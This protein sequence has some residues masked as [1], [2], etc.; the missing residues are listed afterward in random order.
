MD[1]VLRGLVMY[2]L[3]LLVFRLSGKRTL[4]QIT[5]FDFV[6]LLIISE[7]TQQAL[8]RNDFSMTQSALV[9]LT[10]VAADRFADLIAWRSRRADRAL[11]SGPIVLVDHGEP[12]RDRM[13]MARISEDDI[14]EQARTTQGLRGMG[15][16]DFAVLERSGTISIIPARGEGD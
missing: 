6:L 11:N 10:L 1:A 14:L 7:A 13:A 15:E 4:A 16:I 5:A 8:L 3:L 9:I 12:L 2:L